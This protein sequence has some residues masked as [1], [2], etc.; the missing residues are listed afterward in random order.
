MR[1]KMGQ[2]LAAAAMAIGVV[3]LA[4]APVM[5]ASSISVSGYSLNGSVVMVTV[6][7]NASSAVVGNISVQA[8]VG[9]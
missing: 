8:R 6:H 7:N 9:G 5:A 3:M 2:R 1:S 4:A